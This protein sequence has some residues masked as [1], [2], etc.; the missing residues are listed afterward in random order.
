MA[1]LESLYSS[2][3][4]LPNLGESKRLI[5]RCTRKSSLWLDP[6]FCPHDFR[7]PQKQLSF[8]SELPEQQCPHSPGL[9]PCH[10]PTPLYLSIH[11]F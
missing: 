6:S 9:L 11:G 8:P 3:S 10:P 4:M 2:P 5:E 1:A 7:S